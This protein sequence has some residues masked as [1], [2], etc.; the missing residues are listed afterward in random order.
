MYCNTYFTCNT[1]FL[2]FF[3]KRSS[4]WMIRITR[5]ASVIY[6][7]TLD[8]CHFFQRN[9]IWMLNITIGFLSSWKMTTL[10]NYFLNLN[11][12]RSKIHIVGLCNSESGWFVLSIMYR[13]SK[14]AK[15]CQNLHPFHLIR[16]LWYHYVLSAYPIKKPHLFPQG[17]LLELAKVDPCHLI[18][19]WKIACISKPK[20]IQVG[21]PRAS[22]IFK[23]T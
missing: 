18:K 22:L 15:H 21:P 3:S 16:L 8:F 23:V 2:P 14:K 6:A 19:R 1:R 20:R 12:Q 9:S 10:F 4:I 13:L 17:G 5:K 11:R 7:A